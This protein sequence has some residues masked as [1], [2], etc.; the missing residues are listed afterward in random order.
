MGNYP[1]V[2]V[3]KA[4]FQVLRELLD[5]RAKYVERRQCDRCLPRVRSVAD[6]QRLSARASGKFAQFIGGLRQWT[7]GYTLTF[8]DKQFIPDEELHQ[9]IEVWNP[10]LKWVNRCAAEWRKLQDYQGNE[11]MMV[12]KEEKWGQKDTT[13]MGFRLGLLSHGV[14]AGGKKFLWSPLGLTM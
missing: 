2:V 1:P 8:R 6:N 5:E 10:T 9:E 7:K 14:L 13:F 12:L 3:S 11:F 4:E